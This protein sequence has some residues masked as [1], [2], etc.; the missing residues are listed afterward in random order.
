[1]APLSQPFSSLLT[2]LTPACHIGSGVKD[3]YDLAPQTRAQLSC[4]RPS[5]MQTRSLG[6]SCPCPGGPGCARPICQHPLPGFSLPPPHGGSLPPPSW[7]A[8]IPDFAAAAPISHLVPT[9]T[10]WVMYTLCADVRGRVHIHMGYRSYI[11]C[12]YIY[13][14][15]Q[16]IYIYLFTFI[17]IMYRTLT[18]YQKR[19][20]DFPGRPQL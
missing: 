13:I 16:H 17:Y 8:S 3:G 15:I 11:H 1:M 4:L 12:A 9:S 14:Y 6:H 20:G 10:G 5:Q 2:A 19:F 7:A 18:F